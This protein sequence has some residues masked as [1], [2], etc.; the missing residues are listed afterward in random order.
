MGLYRA[1][2][3][4]QR[5]ACVLS[6]TAGLPQ[7]GYHLHV[8]NGFVCMFEQKTAVPPF[9]ASKLWLIILSDY[10]QTFPL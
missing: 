8:E 9:H 2:I 1:I 3:N 6:A 5:H 7:R 4:K 10:L